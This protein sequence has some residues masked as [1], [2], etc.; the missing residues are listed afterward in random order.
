MMINGSKIL[1]T[2]FEIDHNLK[3]HIPFIGADLMRILLN[4]YNIY[5]NST[6]VILYKIAVA[7][8]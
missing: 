7:S 6:V 5:Y 1:A 4:Q 3:T 8:T 2:A